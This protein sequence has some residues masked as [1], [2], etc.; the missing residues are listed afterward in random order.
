MSG[1]DEIIE[2]A[3]TVAGME[4]LEWQKE[5]IHLVFDEDS[6]PQAHVVMRGRKNGWNATCELLRKWYEA[7]GYDI[8]EM[9][10]GWKAVK[11]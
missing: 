7:N 9:D 4:L 6:K 5:Y 11:R 8:E 1:G 2:F 10:G 3:E